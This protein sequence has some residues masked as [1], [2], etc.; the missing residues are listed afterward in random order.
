MTSDVMTQPTLFD[1]STLDDNTRAFV[2]GQANAIRALEKR[3]V[4]DIIDMGKALSDV[5]ERL[6]HGT[7]GG[8]LKHEFD[9]GKTTAHRFMNVYKLSLKRPNLEQTGKSV[10]YL[11]ASPSTPEVAIDDILDGDYTVNEAKQIIDAYGVS[12]KE[13]K[14]LAEVSDHLWVQ[15]NAPPYILMALEDERGQQHLTFEQAR[16]HTLKYQS[17]HTWTQWIVGGWGEQFPPLDPET[18][19]FLDMIARGDSETKEDLEASAHIQLGDEHEAVSLSAGAKKLYSAFKRKAQL[20]KQLAGQ[21]GQA[22]GNTYS[23][24][25]PLDGRIADI[26]RQVKG[27]A[28]TQT[29]GIEYTGDTVRFIATNVITQD[30]YELRGHEV[31]TAL[32][33]AL[34]LDFV[35]GS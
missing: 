20:H 5:H 15:Q 7:F 22:S 32:A 21:A 19:D 24:A 29:V 33:I 4:K 10:L 1:Y 16:V 9:W 25:T 30:G 3:M 11:L 18:Y 31:A 27:L 17:A 12:D 34:N 35:K 28:S 6:P 2:A 26:L 13:R 23:P 8:W 14:R